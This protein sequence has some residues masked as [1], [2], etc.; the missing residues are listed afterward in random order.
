[1]KWRSVVPAYAEALTGVLAGW[2]AAA[3]GHLRPGRLEV[4]T[5]SCGDRAEPRNEV[6]KNCRQ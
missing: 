5:D 1:M 3:F 6:V 4:A 2:Q